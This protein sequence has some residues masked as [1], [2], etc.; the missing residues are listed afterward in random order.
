MK[1]RLLKAKGNIVTFELEHLID[2]QHVKR[3]AEGGIF[4]SVEFE[5]TRTITPDQRKLIYAL[6]K[7][8]QNYTGYFQYWWKNILKH[9]FEYEYGVENISFADG[10]ISIEIASLFI[11]YVIDCCFKW[12]V[13]FKERHYHMHSDA[14]KLLFKYLM[15]R[16]CMCC[17]KKAEIHHYDAIGMGRSRKTYDH[18]QSRYLSLCREHHNEAHSVTKDEFMIKHQ[19]VPIKLN[20]EQL[21]QI[22]VM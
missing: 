9:M 5:D 8:M 21:K 15:N 7:D 19:L 12:G 17:G 22:G 11:E 1:A 16:R 6:F 14:K 3:K 2:L 10:A 20:E 4:A 18:T 13:P